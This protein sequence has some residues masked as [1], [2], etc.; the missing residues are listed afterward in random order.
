MLDD[1][2]CLLVQ[3]S[4]VDLLPSLATVLAPLYAASSRHRVNALTVVSVNHHR[5]S[6]RPFAAQPQWTRRVLVSFFFGQVQPVFSANIE[7]S[8]CAWRHRRLL[9]ALGNLSKPYVYELS[10]PSQTYISHVESK[11]HSDYES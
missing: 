8:I 10:I 2:P 1:A 9:S 11:A 3:N 6:H 7:N 4:I 5:R